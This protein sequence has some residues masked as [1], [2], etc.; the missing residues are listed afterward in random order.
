MKY[1]RMRLNFGKSLRY[2]FLLKKEMHQGYKRPNPYTAER[3]GDPY[4]GLIARFAIEFEKT[5]L[6]WLYEVLDFVEQRQ[7]QAPLPDNSK[8]FRDTMVAQH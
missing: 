4:F 6:R 3:E 7:R 8:F 2:Q 5:Y 1:K